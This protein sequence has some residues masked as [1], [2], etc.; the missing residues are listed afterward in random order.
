MNNINSRLLT[1]SAEVV[2]GP[3]RAIINASLTTGELPNIWKKSKVTPV[4]KTKTPQNHSTYMP[5]SILPICMKL[6]ETAVHI[7]LN[8]YL[9]RI[10]VLCEEQSG[11][12]EGHSI[13]TAVTDVT[14]FIDKYMEQGQLTGAVF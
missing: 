3:L 6:F 11:F 4:Y 1:D 5:I 10:G 13:V 14:D 8:L 2:A 7:Q 9:K 12:R